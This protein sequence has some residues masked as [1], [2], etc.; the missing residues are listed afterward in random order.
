MLRRSLTKRVE[1][2]MKQF[3]VVVIT[4]ARQIGKSTL[5]VHIAKTKKK[6]A[7]YFDLELPSDRRKLDDA[8]TFFKQNKDKLIVI[9]EAQTMPELFSIL[10]PVVDMY[11]KPGRFILLGSISPFLYKNISQSLAGRAAYVELSG[12]NYT[13]VAASRIDLKKLWFRGGYP[14]PLMRKS[15]KAWHDWMENYERTFVERDVTILMNERLSPFTVRK[16]WQMLSGIHGQILNYEMLAKSLGISRATA[17]RYVDFME[18]AYLIR[19]L[20]PWFMNIH[21]RIVKSPKVYF[22]DSGLLHFMHRI[23]SYEDLQGHIYSGYSWEGFVI[24]QIIQHAPRGLEPYYYRTHHGAEADLVL[25]LGNK[26]W[27]SVEIKLSNAP[28]VPKGFFQSA[29]DLKTPFNFI[30]KPDGEDYEIKNI[31]VCS[32]ARFIR[33]YLPDL[34]KNKNK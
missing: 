5:A 32:I 26:P 33:H 21:K 25:V 23:H 6:K 28:D 12:I 24:E 27:C 30:I 11:K 14:E 8:E 9:D 29:E 22:R 3:P 13:E 4:G 7:I 15:E 2:L 16:I 20:H 31:K 19:R 34:I 1:E 17:V 10:R 18:A